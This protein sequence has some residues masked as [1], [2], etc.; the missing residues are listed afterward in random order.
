[1][2]E[3][4]EVETVRRG[5]SAL[6]ID[7]KITGVQL[8]YPKIIQG[9]PTEFQTAMTGRRFLKIDRRGKYLLFRLSEGLTMVS[10]LRMEG[11]YSVKSQTE[12]LDKHTHVVFDLDDG[13]QL[14]YNDVRKFGRMQLVKTGTE[15]QLPSL[16]KLGPEPTPE[17]FDAKEFYQTLQQKKKVIKTALLDQTIVAGLGNIYV[18]ETLWM[19]KI[20]PETKC[21]QITME[22]AQELHDNIIKELN[23]AIEA[24]GTT[25]FTFAAVNDAIGS[26]QNEL[27][28][29]GH[30][31]EPCSRCQTPIEKI[32]VGQRGTHFCPNCQKPVTAE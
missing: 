22:Q 16:K 31:G 1:M 2:P 13:R 11:K 24:H 29:Y 7:K 9:D 19:T 5:L 12:D 28:V 14:R 3:L 18:D 6:I 23:R 8:I 4:P 27:Q 15:D 21:N 10:H 25:V 20:H 26:F 17:T 30:K 32:V